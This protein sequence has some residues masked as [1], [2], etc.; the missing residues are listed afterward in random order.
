M[1]ATGTTTEIFAREQNAGALIARLVQYKIRVQRPLAVVHA[2]FAM[3]QITQLIEQI[4]AKARAF[5]GFQKLLGDDQVCIH[6]LAIQ[7]C[8]KTFMKG[9]CFHAVILIF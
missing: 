2:R 3:I 8:N 5:D 9:K 6:V 4:G 7:G 1:F